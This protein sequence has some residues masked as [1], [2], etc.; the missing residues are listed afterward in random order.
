MFEHLRDITAPLRLPDLAARVHSLGYSPDQIPS[1]TLQVTP[2][3]H[4]G[5]HLG[6]FYLGDKQGGEAFTDRDEEVL[7]LFASQ[8]ATA[9]ANAR[10][11]RDEQRARADLEAL[12]DTS[13]VG[14]AVFDAKTGRPVSSNR[15]TNRI[16]ASLCGSGQSPEQLQEKLICRF[17]DGRE[18]AFAELPMSQ[19][20]SGT[21]TVRA[22]Q[23]E[24]SVP[25]G[26]R[27][28]MLVNATPIQS[29]D[30]AVESV[31]I[32]M[33]DLAPFQ[34][35]ERSRTDFLSMVS[36]ELRAPL[37]SI[38]G[39]AASAQRATRVLDPAEV[40]QFFR[41]I[42]AQADRMDDLISDLLDVGRIETG[43]LSVAPETAEVAALVDQAR[44]TFLTAG[45]RHTLKIDVP[46]GLP[47]V[48][49]DGRR[50][51]QA[52]TISSP[53]QAGRDPR[54]LAAP[55]V[56]RSPHRRPAHRAH[57]CEEALPQARRRR[58]AADLH[59]HRDRRRLPHARSNGRVSE[60]SATARA[61]D[62]NSQSKPVAG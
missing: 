56:G 59:L 10:T 26:R 23:I 32:T 38:K 19:V 24:L 3:R 2:M 51:V 37:S 36:H 15:E 30:G 22:E 27:V 14:V 31:I 25:D 44:N 40:R 61:H 33:Q 50:I 55:G 17:A 39:S 21:K 41:I 49:A 18:I 43:T 28:T 5:E 52:L 35:L 13:P 20:L 7:V 62:A 12:V 9:I 46:P 16:I 60:R 54:D 48:M 4:R 58:D 11:H 34:E 47:R 8:A 1:K 6:T 57:L 45:G 29:A 42:E 53:T